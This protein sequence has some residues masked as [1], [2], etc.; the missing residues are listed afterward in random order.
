LVPS[1]VQWLAD[2]GSD[3]MVV[4]ELIRSTGPLRSPDPALQ[5]RG[6]W[7]VRAVTSDTMKVDLGK[8]S[9]DTKGEPSLAMALLQAMGAATAAIHL[10]QT[11]SG[12][13]LLR[14]LEELATDDAWLP[15][16]ATT[17]LP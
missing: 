15:T 17:W 12:A 16:T 2:P 8:I 6:P 14:S 9:P 4:G 13:D 7:V 3:A 5:V 11:K 10:S 1:A